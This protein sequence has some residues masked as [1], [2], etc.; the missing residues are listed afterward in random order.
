LP[1]EHNCRILH[2]TTLRKSF[3]YGEHFHAQA[4]RSQCRAVFLMLL[5][6]KRHVRMLATTADGP[7]KAFAGWS[8]QGMGTADKAIH[9][10]SLPKT[11]LLNSI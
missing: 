7:C 1:T 4:C 8:H 9:D 2:E 11:Q 6:G 3:I 10:R 5:A